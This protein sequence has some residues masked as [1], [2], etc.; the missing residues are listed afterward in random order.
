M[1]I[2]NSLNCYLNSRHILDQQ[3]EKVSTSCTAIHRHYDIENNSQIKMFA[4]RIANAEILLFI[5]R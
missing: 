3:K 4:F 2:I 1:I 5:R